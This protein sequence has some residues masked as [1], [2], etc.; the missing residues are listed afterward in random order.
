MRRRAW[1]S[2]R[3]FKNTLTNSNSSEPKQWTYTIHGEC[4]PVQSIENNIKEE[5]NMFK[6]L[7][8]MEEMLKR[9]QALE[10]SLKSMEQYRKIKTTEE[11]RKTQPNYGNP[12]E[13][14][15]N[16]YKR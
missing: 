2:V 14:R 12:Y 4:V 13:G 15:I 6:T 8:R 5:N 7:Q 11:I 16:K 3:I 10:Q 9:V 1:D